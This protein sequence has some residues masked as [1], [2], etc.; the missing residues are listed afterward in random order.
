ML[1]VIWFYIFYWIFTF[2]FDIN[3][4]QH[5]AVYQLSRACAITTFNQYGKKDQTEANFIIPEIKKLASD[6]R[7]RNLNIILISNGM[8]FVFYVCTVDQIVSDFI[9]LSLCGISSVLFVNALSNSILN[10]FRGTKR[11]FWGKSSITGP[12]GTHFFSK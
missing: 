4:K 10:S 6:A 12:W 3:G 9:V 7:V 5:F 11:C 2:S 8:D 1:Q